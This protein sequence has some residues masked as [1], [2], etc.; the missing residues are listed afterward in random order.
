MVGLQSSVVYR[1][2]IGGGLEWCSGGRILCCVIKSRRIRRPVEGVGAAGTYK[3]IALQYN[4]IAFANRIGR[5]RNVKV[6]ILKGLH[7]HYFRQ[8]QWLPLI[9]GWVASRNLKANDINQVFFH[10]FPGE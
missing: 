9:L 7:I 4:L 8:A 10:V 2:M 6:N 3:F 1:E 5:G